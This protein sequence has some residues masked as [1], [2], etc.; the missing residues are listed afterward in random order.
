MAST[1]TMKELK[2][3]LS[4][5]LN[6]IKGFCFNGRL[7]NGWRQV[8]ETV[9]EFRYSDDG[10]ITRID[11]DQIDSIGKALIFDKRRGYNKPYPNVITK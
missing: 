5:A 10:R 3:T 2:T 9:I 6:M 7:C 1:I 8:N 4:A 11:L